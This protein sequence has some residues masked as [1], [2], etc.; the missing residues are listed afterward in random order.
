MR[1]VLAVLL[2]GCVTW[3]VSEREVEL[4]PLYRYRLELRDDVV[5][6]RAAVEPGGTIAFALALDHACVLIP[7]MARHEY[8]TYA[9][10]PTALSIT[11]MLVGSLGFMVVAAMPT[12]AA[13]AIDLGASTVAVGV[14]ATALLTTRS[15]VT[16]ETFDPKP[17]D[18]VGERSPAPC[19]G[20]DPI[21]ELGGLELIT[22]WGV[23]SNAAFDR[24]GVAHFAIDWKMA[25]E[26]DYRLASPWTVIATKRAISGHWHFGQGDVDRMRALIRFRTQ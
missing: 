21:A 1:A 13:V 4:Q 6:G 18:A 23:R 14:P 5:S 12:L 7:Q 10:R 25:P 19:R 3:S 15:Y 8:I 22:P 11:A 16:R 26:N 9:A 20:I 17:I 24:D 2:S